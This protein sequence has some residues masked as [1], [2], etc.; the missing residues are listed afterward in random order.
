MKCESWEWK[1]KLK[2]I[3]GFLKQPGE[4]GSKSPI[5]CLFSVRKILLSCSIFAFEIAVFYLAGEKQRRVNFCQISKMLCCSWAAL[6]GLSEC[7]SK[8]GYEFNE[9]YAWAA[10]SANGIWGK[11]KILTKE[12][13]SWDSKKKIT[14]RGGESEELTRTLAFKKNWLWLQLANDLL[15]DTG[16]REA[17]RNERGEREFEKK[18]PTFLCSSFRSAFAEVH[19]ERLIFIPR[20]QFLIIVRTNSWNIHEVGGWGCVSATGTRRTWQVA[21]GHVWYFVYASFCA[22]IPGSSL[23]LLFDEVGARRR[24]LKNRPRSVSGQCE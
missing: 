12:K 7:L 19:D 20:H 24:G 10:F 16:V 15:K 17:E 21:G 6:T 14:L 23:G 22:K 3:W 1:M 9:K 13:N 11:D 5:T 8:P 18:R 4:E 2:T